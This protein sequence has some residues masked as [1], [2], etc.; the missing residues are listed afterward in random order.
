[1]SYTNTDSRMDFLTSFRACLIS[2]Q[3]TLQSMDVLN[4]LTVWSTTVWLWRLQTLAS[5]QFSVPV[6]VKGLY[7]IIIII[8]TKKFSYFYTS[9]LI[10]VNHLLT[11]MFTY[12]V[13]PLLSDLWTAPEHLR[14]QGISQKGDVYSF[15]II[16]QEIMMRKCTF[17]SRS[18]SNRAGESY[19]Q[20]HKK[21]TII[22]DT[23]WWFI[24]HPC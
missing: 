1:M 7:I 5:I 21:Y 17:Y 9:T 12:F 8:L 18:C 2:T 19:R 14:K 20:L 6:K 15:A 4:P 23:Y 16:S 10:L 24:L 3:A 11:L 22:S 13:F